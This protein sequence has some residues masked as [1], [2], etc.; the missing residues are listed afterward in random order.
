MWHLVSE[1]YIPKYIIIL[2]TY[3]S[4]R[5]KYMIYDIQVQMYASNI[6]DSAKFKTSTIITS[7]SNHF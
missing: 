6:S 5:F 2:V 7:I 4:L 1:Y 3:W